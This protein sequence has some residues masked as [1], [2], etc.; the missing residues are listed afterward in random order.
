M[1][2]EVS[3]RP[4]GTSVSDVVT[5]TVTTATVLTSANLGQVIVCAGTSADYQ[6]TLPDAVGQ[7]GK[8]IAVL[9]S[10][11]LT[12]LVTIVGASGQT[13][14]GAASRLL[15]AGWSVNMFSDGANWQVLSSISASGVGPL[16]KRGGSVYYSGALSGTVGGGD[17]ATLSR[18]FAIP[19]SP[20]R[21]LT[22]DRIGIEV[23]TTGAGSA[24]RLGIYNDSDGKPDT[25]LLDAGTVDSS[26]STGFKEATIS[27]VLNNAWYWLVCVAQG[28]VAPNVR[29]LITIHQGAWL[30]D[31]SVPTAQKLVYYRDTVSGALP[32]TWGATVNTLNYVPLIQVRV[33]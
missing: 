1:T 14:G 15:V 18:L 25:L 5:T 11:A 19:F 2:A 31:T 4:F 6:V 9:G 22:L 27:Q 12:K 16:P 13:I 32:A 29:D 20:G 30:G 28:G 3:P 23:V 33:V 17:P 26:T 7:A 24:T 8:T 21:A 10:P